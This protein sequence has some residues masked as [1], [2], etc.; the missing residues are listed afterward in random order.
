[1]TTP[2]HRRDPPDVPASADEAPRSEA[3]EAELAALEAILPAEPPTESPAVAPK[4]ASDPTAAADHGEA[5]EKVAN[6]PGDSLSTSAGR[7][8]TPP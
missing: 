2:E 6:P 3:L 5:A 7:R 4:P 8:A 1:M